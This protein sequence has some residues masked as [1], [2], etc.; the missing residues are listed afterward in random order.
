LLS[1]IRFENS[2]ALVKWLY[3]TMEGRFLAW[4]GPLCGEIKKQLAAQFNY[5]TLEQTKLSAFVPVCKAMLDLG[6]AWLD[7]YVRT[8]L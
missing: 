2:S 6:P 5:L 1:R 3:S 4:W 7:R 8:I